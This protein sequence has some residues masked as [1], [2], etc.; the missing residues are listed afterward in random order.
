MR[1]ELGALTKSGK[2]GSLYRLSFWGYFRE[3]WAYIFWQW[4]L[5]IVRFGEYFFMARLSRRRMIWLPQ[6]KTQEGRGPQTDKHLPQ[7]P[8]TGQFTLDDNILLWCVYS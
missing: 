7:S 8:F 5:I 1:Q 4:Y 3:N 6:G 2:A